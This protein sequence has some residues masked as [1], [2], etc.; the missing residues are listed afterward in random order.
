MTFLAV[1]TAHN[2]IARLAQSH[3][4]VVAT[5]ATAQDRMMIHHP[6]KLLPIGGVVAGLA[7]GSGRNVIGGT[8]GRSYSLGA[9]MATIAGSWQALE[10]ATGMAALTA[11]SR[12]RAAQRESRTCVIEYAS[13]FV[14]CE[15]TMS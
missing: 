6:D 15:A 12:V 1:V 7:L 8:Y 10:H 2:V 3:G 11:H 9:P 5:A 14:G 13:R 4:T